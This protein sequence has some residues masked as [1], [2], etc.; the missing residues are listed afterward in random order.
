MNLSGPKFALNVARRGVL[1]ILISGLAGVLVAG[2]IIPIAASLGVVARDSAN[3]FGNLA[4]D[5]DLDQPL[6]QRSRIVDP[7]GRTIATFFRENRIEVTL[8]DIAP[9][10]QDAILAIEDHRFY[11]HGAIDIQ[12]TLRALTANLEA[13]DIVGGGST[14]TQ[15]YVKLLQLSREGV[16]YADAE[17]TEISYR[18]KLEELRLA[19]QV[20][21]RLS[22]D[23]I[24]ERYLNIAYFGHGAHGVEAAAR[25]YFSTSAADLTLAQAATLAGI[26]QEP[27]RDPISSPERAVGR[28]N[29]VLTRMAED[30]VSLITEA[31]AREARQAD[32]GLE[33]R[34]TPN[35]CV[36]SP[37]PFYCLYVVEEFK[38]MEEWS[39]PA[40][41]ERLLYEGGL[42]IYTTLDRDNQ[43]AAQKAIDDRVYATDSVVAALAS[44]QPG[45]GKITALAQSRPYGRD[46]EDDEYSGRTYINFTVPHE[47]G[48]SLGAQAGSTY[49]AFVLAA[50]INQGVPLDTSFNSPYRMSIPENRFDMCDGPR[51]STGTWNVTNYSTSVSGRKNLMTGTEQSVNTFYAQLEQLTGLCEPAN[52]ALDLG[53]RVP[54]GKD[55]EEDFMAPSFV[56]GANNTAPLDMAE[57]Y[58]T[59]AARG[60]HCEPYAVAKV[61]DRDGDVVTEAEPE[62]ERVLPKEVADGVNYVLNGV[63]DNP[64]GTG[65][66]MRLDDGRDA[67]GKTG[68]TNNTVAVWWV[69]YIPQLA[70]AV[71]VWDPLSNEDTLNGREIGGE[72]LATV[73][74]GCVPGPIWKNTM[75]AIIDNFDREAFVAPGR[76]VI[77][78]KTD[79]VPD[80]RG[81]TVAE[82]TE[83]LEEED[84]QAHV[85][86]EE[87]HESIREGQVIRTSPS[88]G[89]EHPIGGS[90]GL[91]VSLGP[92][93]EPEPEPE[94]TESPDPPDDDD[95]DDD[96]DDEDGNGGGG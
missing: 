64:G 58:A 33:P 11:E 27:G 83:V 72:V 2:L 62:C 59:F 82:A 55:L 39:S 28:R 36:G 47:Y 95:D 67:A 20:E 5:I 86:D 3:E 15:Q 88:T 23:E 68:T 66:R 50:A 84:F 91:V 61:V 9:V 30:E 56:L 49:K 14:L 17:A 69:G 93:P 46:T 24:L 21:Q 94:P 19:L 16:S 85:A 43:R 7:D 75:D 79:P 60:V 6:P 10:M 80:V 57:A 54:P 8:D 42:T 25:T 65:G 90:V 44:V 53:V 87:E 77:R 32:L 92:P 26:V 13:G 63:M 52:L 51:R 29:V 22:K 1:V 96:D 78:G 18:R 45:T 73:C 71:A 48:T 70:T 81:L 41:A 37:E 12:G 35:G 40:V 31:Q 74:G 34:E 38:Q 89:S 4:D 76:E